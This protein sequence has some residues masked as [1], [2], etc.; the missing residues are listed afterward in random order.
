M[1]NEQREL[2][3]YVSRDVELLSEKRWLKPAMASHL[4]DMDKHITY[5]ESVQTV[6][7]YFREL[8]DA[9]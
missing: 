6:N 1:T 4:R 3:D 5:K 7:E 2:L 9:G 8:Y